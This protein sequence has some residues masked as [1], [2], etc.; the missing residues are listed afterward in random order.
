MGRQEKRPLIA[1]PL[2]AGLAYLQF[3]LYEL[4][5]RGIGTGIIQALQENVRGFFPDVVHVLS[6]ARKPD[7]SAYL[8]VVIPDEAKV[9]GD[10]HACFADGLP[11]ANSLNVA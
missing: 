10:F 7:E 6:H 3:L 2:H 11:G 4:R 8:N 1:D 9:V 5:Y